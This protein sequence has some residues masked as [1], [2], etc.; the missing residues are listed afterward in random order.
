MSSG[1]R[2]KNVQIDPEQGVLSV[3]GIPVEPFF[4]DFSN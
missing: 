2:T 4:F 1:L 3:S